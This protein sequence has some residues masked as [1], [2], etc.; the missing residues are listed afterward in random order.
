MN[1]EQLLPL[2]ITTVSAVFVALGVGGMS[3]DRSLLQQTEALELSINEKLTLPALSGRA[4]QE[5]V[6]D[7]SRTFLFHSSLPG[8]QRDRP[9]LVIA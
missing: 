6:F 7:R 4:A 5:R 1:P 9:G 8:E 3:I 2:L